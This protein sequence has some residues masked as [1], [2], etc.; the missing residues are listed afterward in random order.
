MNLLKSNS[1]AKTLDAVN[2]SLFYEKQILRSQKL[3]ICNWL[4]NRC[5]QNGSYELMPAPMAA[6]FRG[7][8]MLFTG[9]K[10]NSRAGTS[11][12]L[13]Q[14]ASRILIMFGNNLAKIKTAV[15]ASADAMLRRINSYPEGKLGK[16]T[17]C[18]TT[19]SCAMWRNIGVGG[20][21][22]KQ[23]ILKA[24]INSLKKRRDGKGRWSGFPFY[25]TLLTLSEIKTSDVLKELRYS[26]QACERALSKLH[27][28][29]KITRRRRVLLER[30]LAECA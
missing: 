6:D 8:V 18:C 14:E 5:G 11:H 17:Y 29:G 1:L 19:C 9:E 30:V 7:P 16:G 26:A 2:E 20:L 21:K 10:I 3:Q 25:Y 24:G 15:N 28:P 23:S 12:V 4:A 13:G 22:N 27:G